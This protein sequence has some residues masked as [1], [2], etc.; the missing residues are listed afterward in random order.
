MA[1]EF[2]GFIDGIEGISVDCFR[3]ENLQRCDLFFLSNYHKEDFQ[4]FCGQAVNR[5]RQYYVSPTKTLYCSLRTEQMIMNVMGSVSFSGFKIEVFDI[6]QTLKIPL[7]N[8]RELK[9]TAIDANHCMGSIM[10]LFE[11]EQKI[12][13]YTSDFRCT[14]DQVQQIKALRNLDGSYKSLDTL[15]VDCSFLEHH[16]FEY[17][18]VDNLA[19]VLIEKIEKFENPNEKVHIHSNELIKETL[20][21]K[22][23]SMH[24]V[25]KIHISSDIKKMYNNVQNMDKYMTD[26]SETSIHMCM[27]SSCDINGMGLRIK[28]KDTVP[29]NITEEEESNSQMIEENG[30]EL[31]VAHTIHATFDEVKGLMQICNPAKAIPCVIPRKTTKEQAEYK[32]NVMLEEAT[33]IAETE[34]FQFDGFIEGFDGIA[35]DRFNDKHVQTC[36]AFFLSHCHLDHMQNIENLLETPFQNSTLYCTEESFKILNNIKENLNLQGR[37]YDSF[38]RKIQPLKWGVNS[39]QIDVM[40]RCYDPNLPE[41]DASHSYTITVTTIPANHCL[42]SCMFLFENS[43][44][45]ETVL[46]TGD[47]RFYEVQLPNIKEL[48]SEDG[49]VK[50]LDLVYLDTTFFNQVN[51]KKDFPTED[52]SLQ[53]IESEIKE[54]FEKDKFAFIEIRQPAY[55]CTGEIYKRLSRTFGKKIWVHDK[56]AQYYK[57]FKDIE[58]CLVTD[59]SPRRSSIHI[60]RTGSYTQKSNRYPYWNSTRQCKP[61]YVE[62]CVRIYSTAMYFASQLEM[63]SRLELERREADHNRDVR[64]AISKHS[65]H[66]EIVAFLR[67]FKPKQVVACVDNPKGGST[68]GEIQSDLNKLVDEINANKKLTSQSPAKRR[69]LN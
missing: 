56:H 3:K 30:P 22:K 34:H 33:K 58:S 52:E 10:F 24:F 47:F 64:I 62:T 9:V 60:C 57:G 50:E 12:V 29:E 16:Y 46:F 61:Y 13:L 40:E 20:M 49:T 31:T 39:I 5:S 27:S 2:S 35:V 59:S 21:I 42:G 67:Y 41:R 53:M 55:L 68:M 69:K 36:S 8:G 65:G 4:R 63:T 26:A 37:Y 1:N 6:D 15:Y 43:I 66:K 17:P 25:K 23:L 14:T 19:R 44:N 7:P 28:L 54:Y 38:F 11:T 51:Q 45:K 18:T 32:L 48:H